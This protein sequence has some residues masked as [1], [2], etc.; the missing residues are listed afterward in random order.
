M[1]YLLNIDPR[2]YIT[3]EEIHKLQ[4]KLPVT[5]RFNGIVDEENAKK[6]REELE[7]AED[8]AKESKQEIIPITVDTYGG[9]VYSLLSMVDTMKNCNVPIATI[10]ESKAMSAGAVLASCGA[11]GY[12]YIAPNATIMIHSVRSGTPYG[13]KVEE[14]KI[15]TLES[16]RLN[17]I[18]FAQMSKNCNKHET[19]FYD[20]LKQNDLADLYIDANSALKHNLVNHIGI[21][22]FTVNVKMDFAFKV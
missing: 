1:K 3:G 8:L 21:P 10:I 18:L 12:R 19:Y 6:F 20:L 15:D 17:K 14:M 5:I 22:N 2:L 4:W 9:D 13:S 7:I 16:D 11:E